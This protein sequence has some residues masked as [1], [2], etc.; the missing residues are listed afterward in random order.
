M[1]KTKI[2]GAKAVV[3]TTPNNTL[4]TLVVLYDVKGFFVFVKS[5]KN[6]NIYSRAHSNSRAHLHRRSCK[7]KLTL[8]HDVF[9]ISAA[10][11]CCGNLT[12]QYIFC[13][14]SVDKRDV[15]SSYRHTHTRTHTQRHKNIVFF[16]FHKKLRVLKLC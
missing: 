8:S 12:R 9:I 4:K 15:A 6:V 7:P 1:G 14:L 11:E 3:A 10:I 5:L 13:T 16:G 2:G